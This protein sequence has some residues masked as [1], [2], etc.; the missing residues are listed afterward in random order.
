MK[1]FLALLTLISV[2]ISI[3]GCAGENLWISDAKIDAQMRTPENL[4]EL[5]GPPAATIDQTVRP[6]PTVA[7]EYR[8]FIIYKSGIVQYRGY[9][10]SGKKWLSS[11]HPIEPE[12]I[13]YE[14]RVLDP[15]SEHDRKLITEYLSFNPEF[16]F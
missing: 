7:K 10:Y 13:S 15:R 16:K 1:A 2:T 9:F 5:L 11:V 3:P 8:Y 4:T 6:G 12:T 14:F